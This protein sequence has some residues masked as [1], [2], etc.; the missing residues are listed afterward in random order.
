[1]KVRLPKWIKGAALPATLSTMVPTDVSPSVS[2]LPPDLFTRPQLYLPMQSASMGSF[3]SNKVR[4]TS[5]PSV[6]HAEI[7][8]RHEEKRLEVTEEKRL[9]TLAVKEAL[10]TITPAEMVELEKLDNRRLV[11][12]PASDPKAIEARE[13]LLFKIESLITELNSFGKN[14]RGKT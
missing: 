10:G 5:T 13:R 4:L 3:T 7:K 12:Q 1:M 8:M 2:Q 9:N 14:R 11:D 6:T